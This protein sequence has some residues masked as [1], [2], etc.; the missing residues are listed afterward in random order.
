[1]NP[2]LFPGL[3]AGPV[4]MERLMQR[5]AP[6]RVDVATHP[7]RFTPREVAA[8]LADWEPILLERMKACLSAPGSTIVGIDEGERA[9]RLN[10]ASLDWREQ[11]AKY[12]EAREMTI[13]WL[14][15]RQDSDWGAFVVHSERGKQTLY[16]QAN[17]LLGHDLYHI[18]QLSSVIE[19]RSVGTW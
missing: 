2:Y 6:E 5:I 7:G 12:R 13:V 15:E 4:V 10:Y 17:L 9:T 16:D 11:L 18:E 1:M 3:L 19:G 8:H 14:K